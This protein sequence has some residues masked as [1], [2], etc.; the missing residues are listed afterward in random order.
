MRKEESLNQEIVEINNC[1]RLSND[2][3]LKKN[4]KDEY[5]LIKRCM[6]NE[7]LI[8]LVCE[9][10][11]FDYIYLLLSIME[12][13]KI[14]MNSYLLA[15]STLF[16]MVNDGCKISNGLSIAND[17]KFINSLKF[18]NAHAGA[19]MSSF[20]ILNINY[21]FFNCQTFGLWC[22]T[23]KNRP[24]PHYIKL[25]SPFASNIKGVDKLIHN[26]EIHEFKKYVNTINVYS[27]RLN[28][29]FLDTWLGYVP[30]SEYVIQLEDDIFNY[31]RNYYYIRFWM[32]FIDWDNFFI[33]CGAVIS[34]VASLNIKQNET[35]VDI[36][37]IG[38]N[39]D[40][41]IDAVKRFQANL[42]KRDVPYQ[43]YQCNKRMITFVLMIR[44]SRYEKN[45]Y[46]MIRI[47]F[48]WTDDR[49]LAETL[50]SFDLGAC[51]IAYKPHPINRLY[52]TDS[53]LYFL[54]TSQCLVYTYA[55]NRIKKYKNKGV[56][57]FLLKSRWDHHC[58]INDR[59]EWGGDG[60]E[61]THDLKVKLNDNE[62]FIVSRW[63]RYGIV[64]YSYGCLIKKFIS[65]IKER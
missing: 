3:N 20:S 11:P 32:K 2:L 44:K 30:E 8:I 23:F 36:F 55:K 21:N 26:V 10:L 47:Q 56:C 65:C 4:V 52:F 27:K 13:V 43:I 29:I 48:F 51:Q 61:R 7:L 46:D 28:E 17:S 18:K 58:Y 9:Y 54:K 15:K 40:D 42:I 14:I 16:E 12:N 31:F 34:A 59:V 50:L 22:E 41:F 62:P 53:C 37:S 63:K 1:L 64:D 33:A 24:L 39:L 49:T 19:A 45:R 6:V 60:Y 5:D 38:L 25:F 35:S 57:N